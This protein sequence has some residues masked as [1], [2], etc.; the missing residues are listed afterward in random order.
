M[1]LSVIVTIY[2]REAVLRRC[3]DSILAQNMT[4]YE[5]ILVDDGSRDGSR[6]I[7]ETYERSHPE[8]IRCLYRENGGVARAR[9]AGL[10]AACGEYI[11]YVDSDDWLPENVLGAAGTKSGTDAGGY[12]AL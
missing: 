6:R 10:A 5:V 3:V 12:S 1:K 4:N 11:T 2:N 8:R 7:M 9:N